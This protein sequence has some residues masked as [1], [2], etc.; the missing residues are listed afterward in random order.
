M[1]YPS[2]VRPRLTVEH[3]FFLTYHWLYVHAKL[4]LSVNPNHNSAVDDTYKINK[5]RKKRD[6]NHSVMMRLGARNVK[7][8]RDNVDRLS[9]CLPGK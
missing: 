8:E 4:K 3:H 1:M 7:C 6:V 5:K 9:W 2:R